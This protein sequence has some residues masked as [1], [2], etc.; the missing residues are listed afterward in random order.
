MLKLARKD[1][2]KLFACMANKAVVYAPVARGSGAVFAPYK[3]GERLDLNTRL[4]TTS[5]K[6]VFFPQVEALMNFACANKQLVIE[7]KQLPTEESIIFGVRACDARSFALLDKVFLAEQVDRFYEARRSHTLIITLACSEPAETCFCH[8][9]GIDATQPG[10]DITV[11]L[12][13]DSLYWQPLSDK[14]KA[15]MEE[16]RDYFVEA[17]AAPV[18]E[19]QRRTKEYFAQFPLAD[20]RIPEVWQHTKE[21]FASESWGAFSS[22]CLGCGICTFICPTCHC[23]D[24]K[25]FADKGRAERYRCWDS[26]M[27]SDFTRMA[28]GQPRTTQLERFR[29][30]FMHKL[31]YFPENN[32]GAYACVGCGRCLEK[33]PMGLN[34]V[35]VVK[36][37]AVK[38]DV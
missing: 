5:A 3:Q 15:L 9:F 29:Q 37:L 21:V 2:A 25:D 1:L 12:A 13:G 33:C 24:V 16:L 20:F 4:T 27:Y 19:Q 26:C 10:G 6:D 35:K 17:E 14:G 18:Q 34:I 23:Y 38:E 8:A 32:G 36:G 30:R 7:P 31:T 28:G 11:Y 22:A